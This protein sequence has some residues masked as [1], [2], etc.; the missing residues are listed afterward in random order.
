MS[1]VVM[2]TEADALPAMR[3]Q[4]KLLLVALRLL[5]TTTGQET[6][7][8]EVATTLLEASQAGWVKES[9]WGISLF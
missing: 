7:P 1:A 4:L 3:S 9:Y 5:C 8:D 2:K 6:Q